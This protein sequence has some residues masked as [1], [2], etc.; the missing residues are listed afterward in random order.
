MSSYIRR[1]TAA[2][3]LMVSVGLGLGARAS[4]TPAPSATAAS[5][6]TAAQAGAGWLGRQFTGRSISFNGAPDPSFTALAVLAL[7]AAGVGGHAAHAGIAWLERHFTSYVSS[8][9]VDDAGALATLILAATAMGVD[10]TAFGGKLPA[11]QPRRPPGGHPADER[12]RCRAVRFLRS[13][14]RRRLP[15][16]PGRSW[17][18]PN[19][20]DGERGRRHLAPG[21]AVQRRGV[22]VVPARSDNAVSGARPRRLQRPGH[23]L[24]RAG[25]RGAGGARGVASLSTRR[26]LRVLPELRRWLRVHRR[27]QPVTGPGLDRRGHPGSRRPRTTRQPGLHPARRRR[28]RRRHWRAFQLGCSAPKADRGAYVFPGETGPNL[29]ATLQAVPGAAEVAFPL[30]AQT[31]GPASRR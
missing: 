12:T 27:L 22:G 2:S 13:D 24:D 1:A 11:E 17:L 20:I 7:A 29:L 25:R 8:D 14:L 28:H 19:P 26:I 9:G 10:P 30:G 23:Q 21:P 15:P 6:A 31:L 16:G 5:P 3:L 4:A 18:W